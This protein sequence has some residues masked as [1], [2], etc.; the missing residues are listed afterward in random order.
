MDRTNDLQPTNVHKDIDNTLTLLGFKLR[1]KNITVVKKFCSDL[2]D[3][4]AFVGELNQVWTNLMDNAIFALQKDGTLT[5]QTFCDDK[6]VMV[7]IIDNGPGIPKEIQSRIFEPFFT[8]KKVG[9]G[10]GIGLDIVNRIVKNHNGTIKVE[11]EPGNTQFIV[12]LPLTQIEH[13]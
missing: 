1:E 11:S 7:N 5:I 4:P 12:H 9:E 13:K 3:I 8:T 10:A 2:K 6:Q